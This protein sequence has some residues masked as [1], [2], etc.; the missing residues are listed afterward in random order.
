LSQQEG[1]LQRKKKKKKGKKVRGEGTG[2]EILGIEATFGVIL[3]RGGR[4]SK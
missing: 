3:L 4:K 2:G 1:A